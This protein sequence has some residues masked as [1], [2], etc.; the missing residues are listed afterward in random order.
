ML[1]ILLSLT[2]VMLWSGHPFAGGTRLRRWLVERPAEWLARRTAW[3]FGAILVS[4][5]AVVVALY[6]FEGDGEALRLMGLSLGE[7]ASWFI[8]FDVGTYLEAYAAILLLGATRQARALVRH[9]FSLLLT[10]SRVVRGLR[11]V[12]AARAPSVTRRTRP[13]RPADPDPEPAGWFG[14]ALAA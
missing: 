12:R 9:A 13:P 7:G 5:L 2:M 10:S 11:R 8:A 4:V 14:F 6:V 1:V 3:N